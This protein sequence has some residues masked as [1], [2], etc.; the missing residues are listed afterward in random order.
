[1]NCLFLISF[2]LT[3]GSFCNER[4]LCRETTGSHAQRKRER[5][6]SFVLF[7][8]RPQGSVQL[9]KSTSGKN[10]PV[11]IESC[12]FNSKTSESATK[13]FLREIFSIQRLKVFP[14]EQH[15]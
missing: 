10:S 12:L 5:M 1:M 2:I 13:C 14:P 7:L 15:K 8:K 11:A 6:Q 9:F 3:V 4:V